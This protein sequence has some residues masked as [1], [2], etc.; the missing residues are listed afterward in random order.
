MCFAEQ[1]QVPRKH[2]KEA[3]PAPPEAAKDSNGTH[4]PNPPKETREESGDV[5]QLWPIHRDVSKA[6]ARPVSVS[7]KDT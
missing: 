3:Y 1:S 5:P 2:R 7:C 6:Y 4:V